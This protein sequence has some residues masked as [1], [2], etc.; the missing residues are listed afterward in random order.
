MHDVT[1]LLP[2][3]GSSLSVSFGAALDQA[4]YDES[5]GISGMRIRMDI[6]QPPPPPPPWELSNMW[7]TLWA[8]VTA[9]AAPFT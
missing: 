2:H 4:K 3:T 9:Q 8:N 1:V 5:F 6:P 7:L